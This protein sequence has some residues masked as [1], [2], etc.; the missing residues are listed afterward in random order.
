MLNPLTTLAAAK[1]RL[2]ILYFGRDEFSCQVFEKLYSATGYFP[3]SLSTTSC[4]SNPLLGR[5]MAE[6]DHCYPT[7]SDDR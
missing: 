1:Q 3:P 7:G 6:S 4:L 5:C 2:N